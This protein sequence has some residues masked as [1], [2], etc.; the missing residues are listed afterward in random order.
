M[1]TTPLFKITYPE[2]GANL[3]PL[4]SWFAAIANDVENA[5]TTG[6]GGAARLANSDAE[7]NTIFPAPVQGNQVLRPDKGYT[8]QYY[9][10]WNSSS[11]PGGAT[12]AGWYPVSGILPYHLLRGKTMGSVGVSASSYFLTE[13]A[14]YF[15]VKA[16]SGHFQTPTAG[17]LFKANLAGRYNFQFDANFGGANPVTI[18][19]AKKNSTVLDAT[20]GSFIIQNNQLTGN[21]GGVSLSGQIDLAVGDTV[22]VAH[23]FSIGGAS[24]LPNPNTWNAS[25]RFLAP[26]N[27]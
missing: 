1:A 2:G 9:G 12:P 21:T 20:T 14:T 26:L 4:Q 27:Y 13:Y 18:H 7:R 24:L 11:N 8:E 3:T 5:L 19:A 25:L 15:D 10:L 6:L 17:T 22:S 23:W 16:T